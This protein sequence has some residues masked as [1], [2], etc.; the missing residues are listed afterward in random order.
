MQAYTKS[1]GPPATIEINPNTQA[2]LPKIIVATTQM[3][4][5]HDVDSGQ[6]K[7]IIS[8]IST[9]IKIA[10]SM[11]EERL[12]WLNDMQEL[13]VYSIESGVKTKVLE[14]NGSG[15]TLTMD[16]VARSLYY[17]EKGNEVEGS[18]VNKVDLNYFNRG[19]LHVQLIFK[20]SSMITKLEVSPFT[21]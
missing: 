14:M 4:L 19:M 21:R 9:P 10:Y 18:S 5:I 15:T 12:Y 17:A 20:T 7:T 13:F 16:W 6:N 8:G 11:S 2:V 1:I 3:V